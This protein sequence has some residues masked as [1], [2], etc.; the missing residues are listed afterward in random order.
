MPIP[1]TVYM[2]ESMPEADE[3]SIVWLILLSMSYLNFISSLKIATFL[4]EWEDIPTVMASWFLDSK[5]VRT[6]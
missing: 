6:E 4:Q 5:Q 1:Q 2:G 3:Q